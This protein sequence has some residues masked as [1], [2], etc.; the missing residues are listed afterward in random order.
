M[1]H[2]VNDKLQPLHKAIVTRY[3]YNILRHK[4]TVRLLEA[5]E[6]AKAHD[7]EVRGIITCYLHDNNETSEHKEE[8]PPYVELSEIK[9]LEPPHKMLLL[10]DQSDENN[11]DGGYI[12]P[13]YI[14]LRHQE[15]Y[16][17]CDEIILDRE[18]FKIRELYDQSER[19][20]GAK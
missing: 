9:L 14:R 6:G 16:I 8:L 13:L 3:D 10:H 15:Y 20:G 7:L 19:E 11:V 12:T 2:Y 5:G 18:V 17:E 4:L 1:L